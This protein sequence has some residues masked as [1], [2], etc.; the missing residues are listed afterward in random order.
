MVV[1]AAQADALTAL[2]EAEGERAAVIGEVVSGP[3]GV[4]LRP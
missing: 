4:E 2:L 1:P 3:R